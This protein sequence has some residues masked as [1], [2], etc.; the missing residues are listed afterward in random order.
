MK[1]HFIEAPAPTPN[2]KLHLG[3]LS[4]PYIAADVF[5]RAKQLEGA[6]TFFVCDFDYSQTYVRLAALKNNMTVDA[7]LEENIKSIKNTFTNYD[8][9]FDI[10]GV[11]NLT[12]R[13]KF[14]KN[15]MSP[16]LVS[17]YVY[18]KKVEFFYDE[19]QKTFLI[20]AFIS[21]LCSKCNNPTKG[22]ACELCGYYNFSTDIINPFATLSPQTVLTK[23]SCS[24]YML[25]T[26]QLLPQLIKILN[27]IKID[28]KVREL[29]DKI[30]SNIPDEFPVTLPLEDGI[31]LDNNEMIRLTPWLEVLGGTYYLKNIARNNLNYVN[32]EEIEHTSFI[33]I[34]N[35]F[36]CIIIYNLVRI[37]LG[38]DDFPNQYLVNRFYLKNTTKF[39]TRGCSRKP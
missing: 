27:A 3:H 1:K 34:D 24:V 12:E 36:Y 38:V 2:G 22:G 33:G 28:E 32:F 10:L 29:I 15:F 18:E 11:D 16:L 25:K 14:I 21:G 13:Q 31:I 39:S 6:A 7:L 5:N 8:I 19:T 30:L 17:T 9:G 23:K 20:E 26:K 37:C 35:T 4:G